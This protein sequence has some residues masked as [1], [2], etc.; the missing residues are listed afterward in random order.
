M[1][2]RHLALPASAASQRWLTAPRSKGVVSDWLPPDQ[3]DDGDS[4]LESSGVAP[5]NWPARSLVPN[6]S[7][8]WMN[9]A[10]DDHPMAAPSATRR[11]RATTAGS[12]AASATAGDGNRKFSSKVMWLVSRS[13]LSRGVSSVGSGVGS[14]IEGTGD[15]SRWITSPIT[16]LFVDVTREDT[17]AQMCMQMCNP[18]AGISDDEMHD[19]LIVRRVISRMRNPQLARAMQTWQER[20]TE[21]HE[22]QRQ[23]MRRMACH[24]AAVAC[25]HQS[26]LRHLR[27]TSL[28]RAM[29]RWYESWDASVARAQRQRASALLF[30]CRWKAQAFGFWARHAAST[31]HIAET[32]QQLMASFMPSPHCQVEHRSL[33]GW[34]RLCRSFETWRREGI[35]FPAAH[36]LTAVAAACVR[37][38]LSHTWTLWCVAIERRQYVLRLYRL[39]HRCELAISRLHERQLASAWSLWRQGLEKPSTTSRDK[40][41]TT[42]SPMGARPSAAAAEA[43]A[44]S[45]MV[46]KMSAIEEPGYRVQEPESPVMEQTAQS[47]WLQMQVWLYEAH[48]LLTDESYDESADSPCESSP[49]YSRQTPYI[50]ESG[51]ARTEL[52]EPPTP[53]MGPRRILSSLIPSWRSPTARWRASSSSGRRTSRSSV[54]RRL[55]ELE[56]PEAGLNQATSRIDLL[57]GRAK[58]QRASKAA[59]HRNKKR[60]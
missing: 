22:A 42:S 29:E 37:W 48:E 54:N 32:C 41:F 12:A 5:H 31:A 9:E 19:S 50:T 38:R 23:S 11:R 25:L 52:S 33:D 35:R 30:R 13:G 53:N 51:Q 56:T 26:M 18:L 21:A 46:W 17:T 55:M 15:I 24:A 49:S 3:L 20:C 45:S 34:A 39:W 27:L 7:V 40:P 8:P 59:L 43:P 1:E 2:A 47:R 4:F 16:N 36:T 60:S 44:T 57:W 58:P 14:L 28:P 6:P 10:S